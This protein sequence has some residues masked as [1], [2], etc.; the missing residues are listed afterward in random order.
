VRWQE[1][2]LR[3]ALIAC[4][5]AAIAFDLTLWIAAP[6]GLIV[7]ATTGELAVR[8]YAANAVDRLLLVCGTVVTALVLL[9]LGLNL[10]PWGLTRTTWAVTWAILSVGVLAWRGRLRTD[11]GLRAGEIGSLA[12]WLLSASLIFVI[13]G[14]LALTGVRQ[15]NGRSTLAFSFESAS[16]GSVVVEIDATSIT[17]R[18]RIAAMSK[19]AGARPYFSRPFTIRSGSDGERFFKHVPV[20]IAGVWIISLESATNGAALRRL[21]VVVQQH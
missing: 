17:G 4:L 5:F 9:G 20:N 11:I 3:L 15:W 8:P 14:M 2:A 13:A 6:L 10:T 19:V 18:Y 12:L 7:I 16:A 1:I 21:K